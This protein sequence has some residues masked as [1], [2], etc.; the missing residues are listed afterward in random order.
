[1]DRKEFL[2]LIGGGTASAFLFN[3]IGCS[4]G[5][6]NQSSVNGPNGVDFTLD[7]SSSANAAL[8][9]KGGYCF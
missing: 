6:G 2:S 9:A 5:N 1:M 8:N 4:K 3:C 7:L